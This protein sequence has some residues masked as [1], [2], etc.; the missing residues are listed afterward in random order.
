MK[1]ILTTTIS[2]LYAINVFSQAKDNNLNITPLTGNFYI[3]TTYSLYQGGKTP[4]NGM[5]LVTDKGVV[6]FDTPWDTTQFQPLI[7]SIQQRHHKRVTVC[8]S[9]HFHAD[10]TAGL[11]YYRQLGIKTYTTRR[12]DELSRKNNMKRAEFLIDKD[13]VFSVGQYSFQTYYPGEGH[14]ADN[15]VIWFPKEK[16]LYGA[17]LIKSVENNTLGFLGD[18][19]KIAYASTIRNVQ[20]K[21]R[22]PKYIIVGH[23]DWSSLQSLAHTLTMAEQLKKENQPTAK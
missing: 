10:R 5:Y 23:D 15:I 3:Y 18:A 12:T 13:T 14:T 1:N 4:A 2:F 17:C 20:Q 16:I 6:L 11:E 7:D 21:C 22:Q 19:N 9:T 8:I